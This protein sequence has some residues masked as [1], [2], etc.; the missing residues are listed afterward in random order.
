M[1]RT[2]CTVGN[3]IVCG[4]GGADKVR[5]PLLSLCTL[6]T[7]TLKP[8]SECTA[9]CFTSSSSTPSTEQQEKQQQQ[10]QQRSGLKSWITQQNHHHPQSLHQ[11]Q[12]PLQQTTPQ[13]C[14]NNCVQTS[15]ITTSGPSEKDQLQSASSNTTN[16]TTTTGYNAANDTGST[17]CG[18]VHPPLK[19]ERPRWTRLS[20][21]NTV[22]T[23]P[24]VG[25]KSLTLERAKDIHLSHHSVS[26]CSSTSEATRSA[27]AMVRS[28]PR[29]P[30]GLTH[31]RRHSEDNTGVDDIAGA[32]NSLWSTDWRKYSRK[33]QRASVSP[34]G[35]S[36]STTLSPECDTPKSDVSTPTVGRTPSFR[37]VRSCLENITKD[38]VGKRAVNQ[39][40]LSS[41]VESYSSLDG[42]N[43]GLNTK[44]DNEVGKTAQKTSDSQLCGLGFGLRLSD[45]EESTD[46]NNYS[47]QLANNSTCNPDLKHKL[48]SDSA[49]VFDHFSPP[50]NLEYDPPSLQ[51]KMHNNL[52]ESSSE[53]VF[54]DSSFTTDGNDSLNLS[55]LP[56]P[57]CSDDT[58]SSDTILYS[59]SSQCV[60]DQCF[61]KEHHSSH[62][63]KIGCDS[64]N[65][66]SLS[67]SVSTLRALSSFESDEDMSLH[68]TEDDETNSPKLHQNLIH[69]HSGVAPKIY[70]Q[71]SDIESSNQETEEDEGVVDVDPIALNREL[72]KTFTERV[73]A[74]QNDPS[75]VGQGNITATGENKEILRHLSKRFLTHPPLKEKLS[76]EGGTKDS[77]GFGSIIDSRNMGTDTKS[78]I[79]L[80]SSFDSHLCP[81]EGTIPSSVHDGT[82]DMMSDYHTDKTEEKSSKQVKYKSHSAPNR[83]L[84]V[85][86]NDSVI[87]RHQ[88]NEIKKTVHDGFAE[89]TLSPFK[90]EPKVRARSRSPRPDIKILH[91]DDSSSA[92]E[93]QINIPVKRPSKKRQRG[94]SSEQK[95]NV[96]EKV[97]KTF[98]SSI[99]SSLA[100]GI[101]FNKSR[102]LKV[103]TLP[104]SLPSTPLTSPENTLTRAKRSLTTDPGGRKLQPLLRSHSSASV[105]DTRKGRPKLGEG[106]RTA[107]STAADLF[108]SRNNRDKPSS[109]TSF[110]PSLEPICSSSLSLFDGPDEGKVS[111]NHMCTR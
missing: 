20:R 42:L 106:I 76:N 36:T 15:L 67:K 6:N 86:D 17:Q 83:S 66:E 51:N 75:K 27:S 105:L 96:T 26:M 102:P 14:A 39:R 72:Y 95:E 18:G 93:G 91:G 81:S 35:G 69:V 94:S 16:T 87:L 37:T 2:Q 78:G 12:P 65:G 80:A 107:T 29:V 38:E 109:S 49:E 22:G 97:P 41:N 19:S 44:E 53:S 57:I 92:E 88:P 43:S 45:E 98:A 4:G 85:V 23:L 58:E 33:G 101:K 52:L 30:T 54:P 77:N 89:S 8:L 55:K 79:S 10:Q 99:S 90:P 47:S 48:N 56:H 61:D 104:A 9:H 71:L 110:S 68:V 46:D 7:V 63:S 100:T 28:R 111:F 40:V 13:L 34:S 64:S 32:L 82:D 70:K 108:S 59:E 11:Q 60:S 5:L 62:D 1:E 3:S 31:D 25:M 103:A 50:G 21:S 73:N 84:D 74:S 24:L